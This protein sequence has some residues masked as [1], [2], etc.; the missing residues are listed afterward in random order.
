MEA[1]RLPKR[2]FSTSQLHGVTVYRDPRLLFSAVKTSNYVF[3]MTLQ[4]AL[5]FALLPSVMLTWLPYEPVRLLPV[6]IMS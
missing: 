5:S 4:I 3:I 1:A 6:I 2:W